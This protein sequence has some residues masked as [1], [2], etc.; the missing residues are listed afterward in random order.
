MH[1]GESEGAAGPEEQP[2]APDGWA[3]GP[4]D[5]RSARRRAVLVAV[6]VGFW[7]IVQLAVPAWQLIDRG[8]QA[9]PRMFGWQMFSH[10]LTR[11]AERFLVTTDAGTTEVRVEEIVGSLRREVR[12]GPRVAAELCR[13]PDVVSVEVVDVEYGSTT[14]TCR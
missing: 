4:V 2:G 12:Y 1:D 11:P 6:V 7:V 14:T 5:A 13:D 10:T 3:F 9:R 8:S